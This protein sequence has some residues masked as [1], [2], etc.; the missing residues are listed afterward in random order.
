M[1]ARRRGLGGGQ[2]GAQQRHR[3]R[4]TG[5]GDR[6]QAG[7]PE[8]ARTMRTLHDGIRTGFEVPW[9]YGLAFE[10]VR[11]GEC[12]FSDTIVRDQRTGTRF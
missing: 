12:R 11:G 6:R 3:G 9:Q 4:R 10:L 7:C 5:Q 8:P 2:T 1:L